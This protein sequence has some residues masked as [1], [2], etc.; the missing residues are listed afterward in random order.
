[1][2]SWKLRMERIPTRPMAHQLKLTRCNGIYCD[3]FEL[4][5]QGPRYFAGKTSR[6]I[7]EEENFVFYCWTA[8]RAW[9]IRGTIVSIYLIYLTLHCA[10]V[11]R[12]PKLKTTPPASNRWL[13]MHDSI[14]AWIQTRCHLRQRRSLNVT[15][16]EILPSLQW[17]T[18]IPQYLKSKV[19]EQYVLTLM[20]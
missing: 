1:M 18:N 7:I 9:Q 2:W 12:Y 5:W 8:Q 15:T 20:T 4:F 17:S 13:E 3:T 10:N 19:F 14:P 16:L 11:L 6:G